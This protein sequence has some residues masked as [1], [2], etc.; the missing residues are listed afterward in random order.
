MT[1]GNAPQ[2]SVLLSLVN[3]SIRDLG[4]YDYVPWTSDDLQWIVLKGI[5]LSI[6]PTTGA[7]VATYAPTQTVYQVDTGLS[8]PVP[9]VPGLGTPQPVEMSQ[10]PFNMA[11]TG[12]RWLY[13]LG[14]DTQNPSLYQV[15]LTTGNSTTLCNSA[16]G[17][18]V[19]V[20]APSDQRVFLFTYD[21]TLQ[22]YRFYYAKSA[23][24]CV[25][26]NEFPSAH[27]FASFLK[28]TT[29]GFALG[30][31]DGN[32]GPI[33]DVVFVP[34]DG[35]PPMKLSQTA[36]GNWYI[37]IAPTKDRVVLA[38]PTPSDGVRRIFSFDLH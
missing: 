18:K 27:P 34:I 32:D 38:G 13:G 7:Q 17:R 2:T 22:T 14:G 31:N 20:S 4:Q 1:C 3:G 12:G 21:A 36:D 8:W 35:R 24:E 37:D 11:F 5:S 29:V 9:I 25:R 23:T 16:L 30:L 19:F 26:I 15:D 10:Q 33:P 6:D 28:A